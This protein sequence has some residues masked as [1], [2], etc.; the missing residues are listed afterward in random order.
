MLLSRVADSLYW[1]GRYIER[2]ERTARL[3]DVRLDLGQDRLPESDGWDFTGLYRALRSE[4]PPEAQTVSELVEELMF[5]P[6][7]PDAVFACVTVARENARQVREEITSDMWEQVNALFLRLKEARAEGT[8]LDRPHFVCRMA[9][10]GVHLFEGVT[11]A[12]MGHGE[13]WH[14]LRLGRFIERASATA[15]LVDLHFERGASLPS[16]HVD[17]V[18]LLRSC[19]ALEGYG[20]CYTADLRPDRIAEFLILNPE[21]P[22][23]VR[24]AA[25]RIESSLR[26]IAQ[27]TGRGASGRAE[28]L[29]GRLHAS[30]DYGQV[31]EILG[32]D[33]HAYLTGIDRQCSAIHA[34]ICQSYI[35]YSIESAIPA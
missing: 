16:N 26:A 10:D 27:I 14:H 2:A 20:R 19:S 32:D 28:R 11:D 8:W 22:R 25:A 29:A 4:T 5:N 23:S 9:M 15:A 35:F 7:C 21:F 31:D 12:T 24:F 3:I 34:A 1:I 33:M 18:G 6:A 13:G 30:L 17:W